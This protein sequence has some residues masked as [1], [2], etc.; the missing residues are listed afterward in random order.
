MLYKGEIRHIV[1][2]MVLIGLLTL[3]CVG[4]EIYLNS[5]CK[6]LMCK[7]DEITEQSRLDDF[8]ALFDKITDVWLL[9]L[10]HSEIDRLSEAYFL[11][12]SAP[13]DAFEQQ[14]QLLIHFLEMIPDRT[15]LSL[16]NIL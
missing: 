10:P 12:Y 9:L 5:S 15:R 16:E 4:S 1:L 6:Y 7:L 14:K 13:K 3:I 8:D 11:M 2:I